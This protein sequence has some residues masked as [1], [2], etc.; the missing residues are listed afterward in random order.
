MKIRIIILFVAIA[1][2]FSCN[3]MVFKTK[4]TG[5]VIDIDTRKP[6]EGAY[7]VAQT[8]NL[9]AYDYVEAAASTQT[10]S[11]GK[12]EISFRADKPSSKRQETVEYSICVCKEPD[13]PCLKMLEWESEWERLYCMSIEEGRKNELV[14]EMEKWN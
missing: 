13:Y 1:L 4:V 5:I 7:V 3:K 12:F 6:I 14:I 9:Y 8:G 10:D 2:L 11:E